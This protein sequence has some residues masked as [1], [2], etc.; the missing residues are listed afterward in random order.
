MNLTKIK[1][2]FEAVKGTESL[3][4]LRRRILDRFLIGASVI[5]TVLFVF[6]SIPLIKRG[7]YSTIV[8]Y[9]AIYLFTLIITIV[10]KLPYTLRVGGY[11]ALIYLFGVINIAMS[12]L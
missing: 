5:G 6:S 11:L 10:H 4:Q 12:G 8:L 7:L 3:Q 2:F 9:G 1:S